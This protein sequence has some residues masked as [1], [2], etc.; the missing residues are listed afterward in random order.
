MPQINIDPV[1][2]IEGHQ[3]WEVDVNTDGR[4]HDAKVKGMM[5]RGFEIILQGRDPRDAIIICGRI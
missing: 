4:S 1:N 3:K 5:F 2:R